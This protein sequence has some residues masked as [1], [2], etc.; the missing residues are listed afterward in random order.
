MFEE[1]V[2]S[3]VSWRSV[4]ISSDGGLDHQRY[5]RADD[6]AAMRTLEQCLK[7]APAYS[8]A[9]LLMAQLL[10]RRDRDSTKAANASLEQVRTSNHRKLPRH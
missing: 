4:R 6:E 10:L 2:V 9:H 3:S 8:E 1:V 7:F 5:L